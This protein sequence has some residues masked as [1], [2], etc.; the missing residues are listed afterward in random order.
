MTIEQYDD[1]Y[2][3]DIEWIVQNFQEES[4][5]EFGIDLDLAVLSDTIEEVKDD[6]YLLIVEGKA[7]GIL[8]GRPVET[9]ISKELVWQEMIWFV[10]K[11]YRNSGVYFLNQVRKILKEKGFASMTIVCME[12]SQKYK[13]FALYER[14][15]F[16]PME[17]HFIGRL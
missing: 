6:I 7:V 10:L 2:K 15:G 17:H 5:N 14:L 12:N 1:K 8:A 13:L 9:P 4:L 3:V 16:K 11:E